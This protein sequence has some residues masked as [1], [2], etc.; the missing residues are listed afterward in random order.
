MPDTTNRVLSPERKLLAADELPAFEILN[1]QSRAPA[2]VVCD[3]A[4]WRVPRALADLGLP[5]DILR[6]HIGWDIGA[7]DVARRLAWRFDT[8]VII[9]NYSR[10]V[11][12]LN[13]SLDD[14]TSIPAI[15]D[16]TVIPGNR[17]PGNRGL[18]AAA[19]QLRVEALFRPYHDKIAETIERARQAKP[20]PV[21]IS[22]HS[23]TP[24]YKGEARPWEVGVLWDADGRIAVPFMERLRKD[25]GLNVGDNLPY[26]GHDLFHTLGDHAARFGFPHLAI[27]IRQDLIASEAGVERNAKIVVDALAPIVADP[28]LYEIFRP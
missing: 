15:S 24:V 7:A 18:D 11:I 8:S 2:V 21:L 19:V 26:S 4:S 23:F 25:F 9:A 13:R 3:H 17:G 20:A 22:I 5:R 6:S 12:D 1:P 10:L 28:S 16:G 14:P 27:E